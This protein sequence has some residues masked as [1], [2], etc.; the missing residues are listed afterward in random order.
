M[1]KSTLLLVA[2]LFVFMFPQPSSATSWAYP[3]VV[4]DGRT[5]EVLDEY[6]TDIDSE[7]G[8]VTSYSDMKSLSGD[9]SNAYKK[10][11]KYYSIKNMSTDD[12]I[13]V[14]VEDG[15]YKKAVF[16]E[17]EDEERIDL[18][19]LFVGIGAVVL[20]IILFYL[21]NKKKTFRQKF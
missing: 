4:W 11:T 1:K 20:T 19:F 12:A 2:V 17:K 3:L 8:E 21:L 14:K 7:V 6:V 5:Y 15:K 13:A 9:F 16:R 10:G 18:S